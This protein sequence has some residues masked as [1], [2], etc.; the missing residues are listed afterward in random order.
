MTEIAPVSRKILWTGRILSLLLASF[1][2]FSAVMKFAQPPDVVSG[3]EHL[4]IPIRLAVGIGIVEIACAIIYLIPQTAVLG[5]ILITGY[6]GGA[7]MTHLRVG[8][9]FIMPP[10]I[11]VVAWI[12]LFLRDRRVRELA[13][14]RRM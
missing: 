3:F 8:D 6:L 2:T 10:I 4:G 5:A 14:L 12:G 9:P 1:L 11:G 13:P 7:T